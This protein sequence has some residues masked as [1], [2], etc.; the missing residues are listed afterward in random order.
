[1]V[2][3]LVME[4]LHFQGCSDNVKVQVDSVYPDS[5]GPFMV[6][7]REVGDVVSLPNPVGVLG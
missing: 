3:S 1:M 2:Q 7:V 4:S 5:P 6:P